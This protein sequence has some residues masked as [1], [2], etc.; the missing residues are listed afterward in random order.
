[1]RGAIATGAAL[2]AMLAVAPGALD[3]ALA[4]VVGSAGR[5]RAT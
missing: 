4:A 3:D 1:M 5:R 2:A